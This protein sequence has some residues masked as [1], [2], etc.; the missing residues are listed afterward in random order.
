MLTIVVYFQTLNNIWFCI[1]KAKLLMNIAIWY[2]I[3]ILYSCRH[4]L[5]S[6]GNEY[7]W[8]AGGTPLSVFMSHLCSIKI[9]LFSSLGI[10]CCESFCPFFSSG[11]SQCT[12]DSSSPGL[13]PRTTS[14]KPHAFGILHLEVLVLLSPIR[15]CQDG[16]CACEEMTH[17]LFP[18]AFLWVLIWKKV[19]TWDL[20]RELCGA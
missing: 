18:K 17:R 7:C 9:P 12:S 14:Q 4:R 11:V 3:P 2:F 8:T 6:D 13:L 16:C 19:V 15:C 1:W 20:R 10:G 5:L